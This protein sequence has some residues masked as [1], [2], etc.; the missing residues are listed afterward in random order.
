M[1]QVVKAATVT[2]SKAVQTT[3][4]STSTS[5]L[6][7]ADNNDSSWKVRDVQGGGETEEEM[8]KR[9]LEE[10]DQERKALELELKELKERLET[11]AL[12]GR[13]PKRPLFV[14]NESPLK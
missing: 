5:D 6:D 14:V 1:F 8:R 10:L 3:S 11:K 12:P 7:L 9:I 2:Y 4:M 13:F